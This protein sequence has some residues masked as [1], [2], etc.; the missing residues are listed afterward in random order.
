MAIRP[1]PKMRT[2]HATRSNRVKVKRL[3]GAPGLPARKLP[4]LPVHRG[5]AHVSGAV[6]KSPQNSAAYSN[7]D[8]G[9]STPKLGTSQIIELPDEATVTGNATGEVPRD[10]DLDLP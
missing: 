7:R 9:A 10:V 3:R 1:K 8:N 4:V 2:A 5:A 6:E